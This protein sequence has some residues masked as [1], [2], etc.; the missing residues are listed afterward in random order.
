MNDDDLLMRAYEASLEHVKT[1]VPASIIASTIDGVLADAG[2]AEFCRPPYMRTRGHGFG[3]GPGAGRLAA[4]LVAG[5]TPS[6]DPAPFRYERLVDGSDL[7]EP[8]M[9]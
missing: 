6:V 4:D 7:G 1:G 5:K 2:F 9:M 8:G 3:I